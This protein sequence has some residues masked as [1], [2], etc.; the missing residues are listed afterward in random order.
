NDIFVR[1]SDNAG[2]IN[3]DVLDKIFEPYFTTKHASTDTG[4]GL[5]MTKMIVENSMSGK[6]SASNVDDGACFEI[7][8]PIS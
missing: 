2:G 5:Y 7:K 3:E 1:I 8:I 4:L 6:V